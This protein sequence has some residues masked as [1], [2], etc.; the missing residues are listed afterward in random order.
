M[1]HHQRAFPGG[2][3]RHGGPGARHM[4]SFQRCVLGARA[5]RDVVLT[6]KAQFEEE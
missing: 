6:L 1:P 5:N 4:F 3:H 2:D